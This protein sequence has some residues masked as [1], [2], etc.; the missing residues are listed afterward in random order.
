MKKLLV[1][2]MI[3]SSFSVFAN[4]ELIE[5]ISV[6]SRGNYKAIVDLVDAKASVSNVLCDRS[7]DSADMGATFYMRN[8][9]SKEIKDS[10]SFLFNAVSMSAVARH[11]DLNNGKPVDFTCT[12]LSK[13][14]FEQKMK[15]NNLPF[16]IERPE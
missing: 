12:E 1:G 13:D 2:L 15:D 7:I 11:K 4:N 6:D 16:C 9:D 10:I 14:S 8:P 3:F 5:C